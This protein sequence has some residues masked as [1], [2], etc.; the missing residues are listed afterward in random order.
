MSVRAFDLRS[1]EDGSLGGCVDLD[2]GF[3]DISLLLCMVW[4]IA[5]FFVGY[6]CW[7]YFTIHSVGIGGQGGLS[8]AD[9][10]PSGGQVFPSALT[11]RFA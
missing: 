7:L 8:V 10:K 2:Q 1:Y 9:G 11:R 6:I 3:F 4:S 5:G